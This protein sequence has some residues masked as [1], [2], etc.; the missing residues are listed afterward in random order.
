[1]TTPST[2][3]SR[4]LACIVGLVAAS[5]AA[6]ADGGVPP[7]LQVAL[8]KK[9]VRF[10]RHFVERAGANVQIL[11]VVLAGDDGSER[12]VAQLGK[13][14]GAGPDIAGRPIKVSVARFSSPARLR[15]DAGDALADL[16][17]LTPGLE[18]RTA[19]IAAALVGMPVITVAADG[20]GAD[21]GAILGFELVSAR[22]KIVINVG[23]ARRQGLDFDS[24]LF[25][26]ARVIK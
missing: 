11:I 13:A 7:E 25:R 4:L 19:A 22:P 3:S 26:L 20:D 12:A 21:R 8:V 1:M 17:W 15:S 6:R 18:A 14:L 5:S 23:Q 2:R 16:V 9:L 10:E 24:D